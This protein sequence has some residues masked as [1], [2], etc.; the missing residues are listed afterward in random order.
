MIRMED[1]EMCVMSTDVK[2]HKM[3]TCLPA[4]H[5]LIDSGEKSIFDE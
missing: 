5:K 1:E 2:G 4:S 3:T